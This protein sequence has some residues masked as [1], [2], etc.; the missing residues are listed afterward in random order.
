MSLGINLLPENG[1]ICNFDCIY[2]ECGL[3]RDGLNDKTLPSAAKV[4]SALEDKLCELML[5][6][7][8]IDTITFSGDGEPTLNPEFPRII[9]DTL[10]L[11]DI[12]FPGVKVAVLTNATMLGRKEIADALRKVDMPIFKLDAPTTELAARIN[13][14]C[15]GYDVADAVAAMADFGGKFILQTMFLR[16]RDFDSSSH[17]VLD[18][19]MQIVRFLHPGLIQAY[20]INR[21]VP[22]EGLEAFSADEI[23]ALVKPLVDEGFN[24][25]VA[26]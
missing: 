12:Y 22:V 19:W 1:K 8:H 11:R 21:P 15:G 3:N 6:E 13:R 9:D 10:R 24:I 16:S 5:S 20:S 18:G 25:T 23:R 26:A 17:E 14:P 7:T 2:C 4:R